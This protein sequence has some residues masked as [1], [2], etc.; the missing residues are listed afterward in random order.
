V[1]APNALASCTVIAVPGDEAIEVAWTYASAGQ[2]ANEI[3][4]EV[5][6]VSGASEF[7]LGE[8]YR[9]RTIEPTTYRIPVVRGATWRVK[10]TPV[11]RQPG[12][13]SREF[14]PQSIPPDV[15]MAG[16]G[17]ALTAHVQAASLGVVRGVGQGFLLGVRD[18]SGNLAF[19]AVVA[20]LQ[21]KW[22]R[23][24]GEAP[25]DTL[26]HARGI[27]VT[28]IISDHWF[29]RTQ[30]GG[31]APTP[32]S[33]WT[34]WET[35]VFNLVNEAASEGWTP[36]YWDI[37]NEPNSGFFSPA[38]QATVSEANFNELFKRAY[39]QIKAANPAAKVA[40]TSLSAPHHTDTGLA[41]QFGGYALD[42]FLSYSIANGMV[43]DVITF[44]AN[45]EKV[46]DAGDVFSTYE[47]N[48][49]RHIS[50]YNAVIARASAAVTS[51]VQLMINEYTPQTRD[52]VPGTAVGIFQVFEDSNVTQAMRSVWGLNGVQALLTAGG[53]FTANYWVHA[54]YASMFGKSRMQVLTNSQHQLSGLAT[55]D[56]PNRKVQ[57][58]IGRHYPGAVPAGI[59]SA[60]VAITIDWPFAIHPLD[61]HVQKMPTGAAALPTP[62][63]VSH[64]T[65]TPIGGQL[66][67]SL[68][69]VADGDAFYIEAADLTLPAG[70][71]RFR[72][73][74]S[75]GGAYVQG[76]YRLRGAETIIPP[77]T[78]G[79]RFR[80]R[81][82]VGG[83]TMRGNNS[84]RGLLV[85]NVS[86]SAVDSGQ[87]IDSSQSRRYW[88]EGTWSQGLW[89]GLI[90][91]GVQAFYNRSDSGTAIDTA[92][93]FALTPIV[94]FDTAHGSEITSQLFTDKH[95]ADSAF[96]QDVNGHVDFSQTRTE[97]AVVNDASN[98]L[99]VIETLSTEVQDSGVGI[100]VAAVQKSDQVDTGIAVDRT[101]ALARTLRET[102][103]A[104][105]VRALVVNLVR[106]DSATATEGTSAYTATRTV[107]EHGFVSETSF[108]DTSA[109]D[110]SLGAA[111]VG[112][113]VEKPF[114]ISATLAQRFDIGVGTEQPVVRQNVVT[115]RTD[116]AAAIDASSL[117][118]NFVR[119]DSAAAADAS[120]LQALFSL[121]EQMFS[122][123]DSTLFMAV[124][125]VN[126]FDRINVIEMPSLIGADVTALTDTLSAVEQR[127]GIEVLPELLRRA[128]EA[129]PT[130]WR[131]RIRRA[132][133]EV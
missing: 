25:D 132:T 17:A 58:L 65:V 15:V 44:H 74:R 83:S 45:D 114:T 91:A 51:D 78:Q 42:Q 121:V 46:I 23:N 113:G 35:F 30:S 68:T 86:V 59:G 133:E 3:Y 72:F 89:S 97:S 123:E 53:A 110:R 32:W 6:S 128:T 28:Q 33:N 43:W 61:V 13:T 57:V 87:A 5:Y 85:S 70:A 115:T 104:L 39:Q 100:D 94:A 41:V 60:T 125:V 101:T 105:D 22:W 12:T 49:V 1:V 54:Q 127:V 11:N 34:T 93:A 10:A 66:T 75:A 62:V 69:G 79:A 118:P 99:V 95:A 116:T 109:F 48:T 82:S 20:A 77:V 88:S 38:D 21:P 130:A 4:F 98:L 131:T 8:A 24:S 50:D 36:E 2:P 84:L 9:E 52:H 117:R 92:V 112:V 55:F 56:T 18:G 31:V 40:A 47:Y 119:I 7:K 106:S 103:I 107:T 29:Q 73:Q 27:S 14:G 90:G 64:T 67:V 124:N 16:S 122:D 126:A 102:A 108:N 96:A 37:W 71:H 80:F 76:G 111:D 63:E 26:L 129:R 120:T 19:P 81:K